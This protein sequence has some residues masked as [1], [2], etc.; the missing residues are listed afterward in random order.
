MHPGHQTRPPAAPRCPRSARR[1]AARAGAGPTNSQ[2][3]PGQP[4]QRP[5]AAAAQQQLPRPPRS[6]P[7]TRLPRQHR[8]DAAANGHADDHPL[9]AAQL[10]LGRLC[11][12]PQVGQQ[13][14]VLRGAGG[15]APAARSAVEARWSACMRTQPP[16]P[17][18]Q[19]QRLPAGRPTWQSMRA[20]F[21]C[22][23]TSHCMMA[24]SQSSPPRLAS[25][26]V[27]STSITPPP[28]CSPGRRQQ[29]GQRAIVRPAGGQPGQRRGLPAACRLR[30]AAALASQSA[31]KKGCCAA[32]QRRAQ[33]AR[34]P[35]TG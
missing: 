24:A 14:G 5:S 35:L 29:R 33:P 8:L 21:R 10:D 26:P 22:S 15:V 19:R 4:Q 16:S 9:L 17:P 2:L 18:P 25:P 11:D 31:C 7:G 13:A 1:S 30:P 32:R 20:G 3:P 27:D 34:A 6:P 28:T 23:S 12:R